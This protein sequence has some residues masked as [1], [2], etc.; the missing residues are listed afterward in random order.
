MVCVVDRRVH[1]ISRDLTSEVDVLHPI[2]GSD[3]LVDGD[4]VFPRLDVADGSA[5]VLD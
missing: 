2:Q 5:E 4:V 1:G 3:R